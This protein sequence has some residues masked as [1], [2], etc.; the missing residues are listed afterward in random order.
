MDVTTADATPA[1]AVRILDTAERLLQ[2]RGYNGFSYATVATEIG[3]TK[4]ALHYHYAGKAEL[5]TALVTRY[6]ARFFEALDRIDREPGAASAKLEA[7]AK[8]YEDVVREGRM[9]LCGMLAADYETLP[10]AMRTAIVDFF[11]R[12]ETWLADL[13]AT[14]ERAGE[15][16]LSGTPGQVAQAV[17]GALEGAMLVSRPYGDVARFESASRQLLAGLTHQT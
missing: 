4:A 2:T 16:H 1:T 5:G 13:V 6:A 11:D 14:G 10:E 15:L 8:I 7:F 12:T 3:V 9:C 17:I